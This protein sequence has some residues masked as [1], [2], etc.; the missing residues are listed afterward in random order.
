VELYLH[1]SVEG[2]E[3][4]GFKGSW[5]LRYSTFSFFGGECMSGVRAMGNGLKKT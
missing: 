1:E 3:E 5:P 4:S 2:F